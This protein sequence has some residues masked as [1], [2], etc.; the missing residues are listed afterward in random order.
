[1]H[2]HTHTHR[3]MYTHDESHIHTRIDT[4]P[5]SQN[6]RTYIYTHKHT[7]THTLIHHLF[8]VVQVGAG[9]LQLPVSRHTVELHPTNTYPWLHSKEAESPG[10]RMGFRAKL[11]TK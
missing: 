1:M 11:F 3:Y 10:A 8:P 6:A 9:T 5:Y 2:A 4:C 7:N